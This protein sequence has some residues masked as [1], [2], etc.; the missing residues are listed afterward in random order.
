MSSPG[1]LHCEDWGCRRCTPQPD[2]GEQGFTVEEKV[3]LELRAQVRRLELPVC[4]PN[5]GTEIERKA[6]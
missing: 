2:A 5:C 1:C 4:C 3:L 6:S